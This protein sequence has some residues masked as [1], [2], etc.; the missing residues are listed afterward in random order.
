M[1]EL[2]GRYPVS[3]DIPV[4]WGE[5]DAF[6]HVNNVAFARWVETARVAYFTRLGL[7]PR[8]ASEGTGPIVGRLAIDYRRPLTYPDTVRVEA[9]VQ[10][11]GT[12]SFRMAYRM[13]SKQHQ[14]EAAS[15]EDV[16]VMVDYGSARPIAVSESLRAAIAGLEASGSLPAC[17]KAGSE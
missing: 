13:W 16:I 3:V 12:T 7:M 8:V 6:Q 4:A 14:A 2:L 17:E 15:A 9:T 5:M 11:I 1:Q 10:S